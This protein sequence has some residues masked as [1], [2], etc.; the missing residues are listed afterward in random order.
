M[1]NAL[2]L[3]GVK[4]LAMKN[5]LHLQSVEWW[6]SVSCQ[7]VRQTHIA[8]LNENE[9]RIKFYATPEALDIIREHNYGAVVNEPESGLC[10]MRVYPLYDFGQVAAW[11]ALLGEL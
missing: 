9:R 6:L 2:P 1:K 8:D 4:R 3:R 7:A 11:V 5:A 10:M